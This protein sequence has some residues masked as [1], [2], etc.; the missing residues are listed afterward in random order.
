MQP[1]QI[2]ISVV[3]GGLFLSIQRLK[4]NDIVTAIQVSKIFNCVEPDHE[5]VL[6]FLSDAKNYLI[7]HRVGSAIAGIAYGYEL[8]RFDGKNSMMYVHAIEVLPEYRRQGI[9][10]E[11]MNELVDICKKN[12]FIKMFLITLKSNIPAVMLYDATGGKA[13]HGLHS[14]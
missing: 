4:E 10:K 7:I 14:F 6:R 12:N 3:N 5:K 1:K 8:Q 9:G 2:Q 13:K 11:I